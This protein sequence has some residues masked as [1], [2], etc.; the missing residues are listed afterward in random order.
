MARSR[1]TEADPDRSPELL[2]LVSAKLPKR[3][4]RFIGRI[5]NE[6]DLHRWEVIA[7]AL[8][9]VFAKYEKSGVLKLTAAER[10]ERT[11]KGEAKP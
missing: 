1:T 10:A 4:N 7:E 8:D 9:D 11:L 6:A 2:A 5:A 3:Y